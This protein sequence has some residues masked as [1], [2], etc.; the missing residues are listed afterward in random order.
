MPSH[1]VDLDQYDRVFTPS[2]L[3]QQQFNELKPAPMSLVSRTED[4]SVDIDRVIASTSLSV[5]LGAAVI[6]TMQTKTN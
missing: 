4:L 2:I 6:R 3:H 5:A 1:P